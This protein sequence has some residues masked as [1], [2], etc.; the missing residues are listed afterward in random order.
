MTL[1]VGSFE[2]NKWGLYDM[3]GNVA[4]WC[5][6]MYNDYNIEQKENPLNYK[7]LDGYIGKVYRGGSYYPVD[8]ESLRSAYRGILDRTKYTSSKSIGFRVCKIDIEPQE[9]ETSS[10]SKEIEKEN[11]KK[12]QENENETQESNE[13]KETFPG[14]YAI[15]HPMS[16][17]IIT[18]F[19]GG[20]FIKELYPND[21]FTVIAKGQGEKGQYYK[22]EID[23]GTIGYIWGGDVTKNQET[24]KYEVSTIDGY[25]DLVKTPGTEDIKTISHTE[26]FIVLEKVWNSYYKIQL[27][28]GTIAY[29]GISV[30]RKVKNAEN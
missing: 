18:G 22:I 5:E 24:K 21:E 30:T 1:P 17:G 20:E 4:E 9:I 25:T 15:N 29:T 13:V 3:H 10:E 16:I 6:D 12:S 7:R 2:P 23:D 11:D 8:T 28:D 19:P 26:T 14:R 27:D